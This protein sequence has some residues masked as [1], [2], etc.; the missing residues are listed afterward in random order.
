MASGRVELQVPPIGPISYDGYFIRVKWQ[1]SA[2]TDIKLAIDQLT[3]A[4]V[5]VVPQGG[6]GLYGQA[7]PLRDQP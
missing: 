6:L 2:R 3:E 1:L 5:L 4:E 7:H